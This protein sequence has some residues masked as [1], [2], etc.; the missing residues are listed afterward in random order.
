MRRPYEQNPLTCTIAKLHVRETSLPKHELHIK[1]Q[2]ATETAD[3]TE[4]IVV[5]K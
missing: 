3:P 5:K 4:I 1:P 2:R